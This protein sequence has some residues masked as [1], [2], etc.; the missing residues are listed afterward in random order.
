MVIVKIRHLG[1]IIDANNLDDMLIFYKLLGF[2]KLYDEIENWTDIFPFG[3]ARIVKIQNDYGEIVEMI[4]SSDKYVGCHHIALTIDNMDKL[5]K[6]IKKNNYI[7]L[8]EPMISKYN[9]NIKMAFVQAPNG[10]VVELVEEL[11]ND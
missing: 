2:R 7:F 5:Y 10:M 11:N 4:L 9:P 6:K 8:V 1:F 3:K